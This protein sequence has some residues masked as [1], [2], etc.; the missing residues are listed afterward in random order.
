MIRVLIVED[1]PM[2][3]QINSDYIRRVPHFQVA[4]IVQNGKEA[5]AYLEKDHTINLIILDIYMP[6]MTGI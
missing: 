3:A 1:D 4:G 2:V 6:K 5:I